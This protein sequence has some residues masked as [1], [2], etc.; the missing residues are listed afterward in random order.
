MNYH[1][2]I[3]IVVAE[4]IHRRYIAAYVREALKYLSY[5]VTARNCPEIAIALFYSI[6]K[7]HATLPIRA[8]AAYA[9]IPRLLR[10]TC[11]RSTV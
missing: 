2:V 10:L 11:I 3:T 4:S 5:K 6:C 8:L 1:A 7:I 9:D